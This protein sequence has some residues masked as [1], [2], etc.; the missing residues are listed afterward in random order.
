MKTLL[1]CCFIVAFWEVAIG[2]INFSPEYEDNMNKIIDSCQQDPGTRAS[3][4]WIQSEDLETAENQGSHILC[5]LVKCGSLF[6][7]GDINPEVMEADLSSGIPTREIVQKILD[8]CGRRLPGLTAEQSAVKNF[9]CVLSTFQ[10]LS[11]EK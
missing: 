4:D 5:R 7:N 2:K 8:D 1:I 6:P 11:G 10:S 9:K 3:D